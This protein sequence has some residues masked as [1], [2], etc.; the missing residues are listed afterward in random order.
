MIDEQI[1]VVIR[2]LIMAASP[3]YRLFWTA[4]LSM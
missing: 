3:L 1:P 2:P 4:V